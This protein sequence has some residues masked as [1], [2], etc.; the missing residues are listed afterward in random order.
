MFSL[1]EIR[2]NLGTSAEKNPTKLNIGMKNY[3]KQLVAY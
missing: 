3:I 2:K 1:E